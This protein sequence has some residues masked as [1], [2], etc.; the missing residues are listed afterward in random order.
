MKKII[1]NYII[2]LIWYIILYYLGIFIKFQN[3]NIIES[4]L[5]LIVINIFSFFT[6]SHFLLCDN[7]ALNTLKKIYNFNYKYK[8]FLYLSSIPFYKLIILSYIYVDPIIIQALS[9]SKLAINIILSLLIN[10]KYYLCNFLLISS[11]I[12]NILSCYSILIFNDWICNLHIS[13]II[14]NNINLV[15]IIILLISIIL[16]S[17]TNV[18]NENIKNDINLDKEVY[19][20]SIY[21]FLLSD[22]I[23]SLF[24]YLILFI[25]NYRIN[26]YNLLFFYGSIFSFIYGPLY[27]FST[28]A[29]LELSSIDNGLINNIVLLLIIIINYTSFCYLY[30]LFIFLIIISSLFII[31]K[32]NFLKNKENMN[33]ITTF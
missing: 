12:I 32:Y 5:F 8:I 15:G 11:I 4:Q 13:N 10:K 18:F 25:C 17:I 26:N 6:S 20:Y 28:K 30:I 9:N 16:T 1:I 3:F 29:Y 22:I 19:I 21:V 27:V 7:N 2:I 33:I 14:I 23:F 31:Y 24:I